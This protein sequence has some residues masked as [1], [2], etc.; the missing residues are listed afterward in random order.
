[1][2]R[3]KDLVHKHRNA[4]VGWAIIC[5]LMLLV[6]FAI[7]PAK[8]ATTLWL[9]S[10]IIGCALLGAALYFTFDGDPDQLEGMERAMALTRLFMLMSACV[11]AGTFAP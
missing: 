3:L 4:R 6:V 5:V 11:V 2:Q 1:M 9:G 8:L 7:N 10:R